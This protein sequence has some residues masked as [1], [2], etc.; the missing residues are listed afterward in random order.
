MGA[1]VRRDDVLINSAGFCQPII[2]LSGKTRRRL[3]RLRLA[4]A[5]TF[6]HDRRN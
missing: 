5:D 2:P 4:A 6:R 3:I 1:D